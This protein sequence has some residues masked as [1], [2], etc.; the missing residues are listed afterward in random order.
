MSAPILY[1]WDPGKRWQNLNKHGLAFEDACQVFEHPRR[2][3]TLDR[4][5]KAEVRVLV[6]A[7]LASLGAVCVLVCT[8]RGSAV[9]CI[10][11]RPAS[12]REREA[13]REYLEQD[14]PPHE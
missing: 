10:S 2:W 12:R 14:R 5:A 8:R 9:R 1:E 4:T 11:L 13:Y 6:I 7:P 3:E